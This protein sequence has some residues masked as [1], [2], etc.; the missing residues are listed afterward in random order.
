VK[1]FLDTANREWIKKWAATGLIDGVTTNPT[2]LSKEGGN[3]KQVLKDICAMIEG[4]VSIEV[5]EKNPDAVLAQAREISKFAKNVAVKIPFAEQY[6]PVIKTAVEEDIK[7]NV[8]L[9]FTPVQTLLVAKLGVAYI[10]PFVGRWDDIGVDGLALLEEVI[11][12]RDGY[13]FPS[14]IIAASVR[15]VLHWQKIIPTGVDIITLP[16][17]VFEAGMKHPLTE[18]GI[19]LFDNDWK[20]LGKKSLFE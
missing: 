14:Q 20:K 9:V 8:T 16:P 13:N 3:I 11:A 6:L 18:R 4:S 1:I 7:I 15:S 5:V 17:A 2:L 10:S 19:E 12:A